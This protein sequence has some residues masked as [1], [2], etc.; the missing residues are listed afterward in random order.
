MTEINTAI[1]DRPALE[2]VDVDLIDVDESYQREADG[3]RIA[4]MLRD[5]RWDH[6]GAVVLA[7]RGDRFAVTDGQHRVR[8]A[9]VHPSITHVP[10]LIIAGEGVVSEAEN[11]LTINRSR[12]AVTPVETFWAGLTSGDPAAARISDVLGK[13]GCCVAS[14]PGEYKP[15]YTNAVS[16][17]GRAIESY[18]ETAVIRACKVVRSAWPDDARALRGA[19]ITAL[20]RVV[21][22][23]KEIDEVRLARTLATK[24][25]AEL[26]G[27][28]ESFRKLSGGSADTA[29]SKAIVEIYNKGLSANKIFFGQAPE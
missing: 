28:A 11:F 4:R 1:G 10:A 7:R 3:R 21:R 6:F 2:W 9:K 24:T 22:A 19:L 12:K 5:F 20:A 15:G 27:H 26:T 17:I 8:A 13:A 18:G 29:L 25:A 23:N 16:A 14:E